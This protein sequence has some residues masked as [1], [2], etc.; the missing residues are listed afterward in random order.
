[1]KTYQGN[2]LLQYVKNR[3]PV[4]IRDLKEEV[5]IKNYILEVGFTTEEFLKNHQGKNP[6]EQRFGREPI[7]QDKEKASEYVVINNGMMRFDRYWNMLENLRQQE[8]FHDINLDIVFWKGSYHLATKRLEKFGADLAKDILRQGKP[9][10]TVYVGPLRSIVDSLFLDKI[11]KKVPIEEKDWNGVLEET[12]ASL[13]L[14]RSRSIDDYLHNSGVIRIA[15]SNLLN[16]EKYKEK[17]VAQRRLFV[18]RYD[19]GFASYQ[20][21]SLKGVPKLAINYMYGDQV[22]NVLVPLII[23]AAKKGKK[24][25]NIVMHGKA[26]SLLDNAKR[27]DIILPTSL[28]Y[29]DLEDH[30][31]QESFTNKFVDFTGIYQRKDFLDY[32]ISFFSGGSDFCA[33]LLLEETSEEL[34]KVK[35][36]GAVSKELEGIYLVNALHKAKKEIGD[37]S[38]PLSIILYVS[39]K[40]PQDTL[41]QELFD[42]R[43]VYKALRIANRFF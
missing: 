34:R 2:N 12:A 36:A 25:L 29:C 26:A 38:L 28:L 31:I 43:G 7:I 40:P 39:D 3:I 4:T 23:G 19:N 41:A 20:F 18:D 9:F 22:E 8:G 33:N 21:F 24:K 35:I 32:D 42:Y 27:G 5:R 30:L 11:I 13:A 37:I 16:S 17:Y 10:D 14:E 15:A 6:I 1:M